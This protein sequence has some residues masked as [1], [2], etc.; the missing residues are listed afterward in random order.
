M[1]AI[2][3]VL[4]EAVKV[5]NFINSRATYSRLF[6]ILCNETASKHDKLLH[7]EVRWLSW[8]NVL[9][10]IFELQSE[11]QIFLSDTTS[12]LSNCFTDEMWLSQLAYLGDIFCR[13]NELSER[14]QAFCTTPF[15][16]HNEQKLSGKTLVSLSK[17]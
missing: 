3:T 16:V 4:T 5:V 11:V 12:D 17:K 8:E 1:V 15:S 10:C 9:S 6:L 13:L 2:L 14:L 7:T